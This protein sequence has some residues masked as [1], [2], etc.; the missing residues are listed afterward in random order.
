MY[1]FTQNR[2]TKQAT[3]FHTANSNFTKISDEQIIHIK[4]S[5]NIH[6][7]PSRH[8]LTGRMEMQ[9]RFNQIFLTYLQAC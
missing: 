3:S 7:I 4:L 9:D 2:Q 1:P 6:A 5:F 8:S